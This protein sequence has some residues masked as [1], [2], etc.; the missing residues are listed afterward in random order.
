MASLW[1]NYGLSITLAAF[2]IV[3]WGLQ[4]WMGWTEFVSEQEQHEQQAEPFG[5]DGYIWRWGQASFENW[6]SEFLQLFT[7]V[8]LTTYLVHR[9]SHESPDTDYDTEAALRRIEAQLQDL[10]KERGKK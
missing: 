9:K 5:P 1:R 3:S 10:R 8:V 7:F 4:T 6:Q 2:F